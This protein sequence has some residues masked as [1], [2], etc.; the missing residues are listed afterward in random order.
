MKKSRTDEYFFYRVDRFIEQK[1]K[2][3]KEKDRLEKEIAKNNNPND[4]LYLDLISIQNKLRKLHDNWNKFLDWYDA[5][6]KKNKVKTFVL[7]AKY[8]TKEEAIEMGCYYKGE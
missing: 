2:L 6:L 5:P 3:L 7:V 8:P 1:A 4:P